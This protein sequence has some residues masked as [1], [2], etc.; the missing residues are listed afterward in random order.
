MKYLY[1][2]LLSFLLIGQNQAQNV[3]QKFLLEVDQVEYAP[4]EDAIEVSA[5]EDW[6]WDFIEYTIEFDQPF[7]FLDIDMASIDID[8]FLLLDEEEYINVEISLNTIEK[9]DNSS[10]V[11]YKIEGDEGNRILKVE[12]RNIQMLD[13]P[14][15]YCNTQIW[16]HEASDV[17]DFY[18]GEGDFADTPFIFGGAVVGLVAY[19]DTEETEYAHLHFISKMGDETELIYTLFDTEEEIENVAHL[20]TYP[21]T[22]TH[23]RFIPDQGDSVK[24]IT[25][26]NNLV[27]PNPV[28]DQLYLKDISSGKYDHIEILDSNGK[29]VLSQEVSSSIDVKDLNSGTYSILLKG[30]KE[31]AASRFIKI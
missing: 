26:I 18:F 5:S 3:D 22:G 29:T 9:I 15:S 28:R 17:I 14:E 10:A 20:D 24:D 1:I 23:Y 11:L 6:N 8:N 7:N 12:W 19:E 16:L 31:M 2:L 21:D 25:N 4:L 27:Y 13:T 30:S